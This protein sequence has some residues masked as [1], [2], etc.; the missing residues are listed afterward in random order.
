MS[1]F[2]TTAFMQQFSTNVGMLLQQKESRLRAAV[3]VQSISGAKTA[4]LLDQFGE[5]TAVKNVT[6]H[7][8]TP[9]IGV[10]QDRRWVSPVD[11]DWGDLIDN[12]D[13]LR[14]A[15]EPTSPIAMAG[16]MA[17]NRAIDDEILLGMF[18]P[19]MT[20]ETGTVA[21]ASLTAFNSGSQVVAHSGTGLTVAK[22]RQARKMLMKAEVDLDAEPVYL[23]IT[24]DDADALLAETTVISL[25]YNTRPVLVDGKITSFMGFNF[26]HTERVPG[27]AKSVSGLPTPTTA[28]AGANRLL[29]FWVKSGVGLG[30]WNDIVTQMAVR[31]DKR[32]ATQ[33]YVTGT[34]GGTRLEEK[35][36]GVIAVQ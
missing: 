11:Y 26:I 5:A 19:N 1:N 27:G 6:R 34:F 30:M 12:Q 21:T 16:A 33:V 3:N 24:A 9:I 18:N 36:L 14:T 29:P 8:D 22:L 2:I 17:L 15:I 31:A 7:G 35:K 28:V 10:P 4:S 20:G 23:A 13:R 32:F 25:D